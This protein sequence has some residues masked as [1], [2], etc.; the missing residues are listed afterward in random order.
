MSSLK[1]S[2]SPYYKPNTIYPND[3]DKNKNMFPSST[4]TQ[5]K[6]TFMDRLKALENAG[7]KDTTVK[8][9]IPQKNTSEYIPEKAVNA[10]TSRYHDVIFGSRAKSPVLDDQ[11]PPPPSHADY[12]QASENEEEEDD[13]EEKIDDSLSDDANDN[14]IIIADNYQTSNFDCP[15]FKPP[16]RSGSN[17]SLPQSPNFDDPKIRAFSYD[18][19]R[20]FL[21]DDENYEDNQDY[22]NHLTHEI[23]TSEHNDIQLV[24]SSVLATKPPNS[25]VKYLVKDNSPTISP[26]YSP[27][28]KHVQSIEIRNK[29]SMDDMFKNF[30]NNVKT[31]PRHSPRSRLVSSDSSSS[32][33]V[34]NKNNHQPDASINLKNTKSNI[35]N[36][37]VSI[38]FHRFLL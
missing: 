8:K 2:L 1:S 19:T 23:I 14:S 16:S 25:Q 6:V 18:V 15:P 9:R 29:D 5:S 20:N 34:S 31:S 24:E 22:E 21:N 3:E 38:K 30:V 13:D 10:T 33:T 7:L 4:T 12:Y 27:P 35:N 32:S 11:L 36:D 37:S 26:P 17:E 28:L